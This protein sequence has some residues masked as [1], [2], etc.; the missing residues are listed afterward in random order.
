MRNREMGPNPRRQTQGQRGTERR[1]ERHRDEDRRQRA[2][3]S[4]RAAVG[5]SLLEL[6]ACAAGNPTRAREGPGSGLAG[7]GS[8]LQGHRTVLIQRHRSDGMRAI[9]YCDKMQSWPAH[10]RRGGSIP[11]PSPTPGPMPR[12]LPGRLCPPLSPFPPP[13][14]PT[15][16]QVRLRPLGRDKNREGPTEGRSVPICPSPLTSLSTPSSP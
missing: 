6:G 8:G 12:P 4:A 9:N 5:L 7:G 1:E 14:T 11:V 3:P 16:S 15:D 13:H 2:G 10:C